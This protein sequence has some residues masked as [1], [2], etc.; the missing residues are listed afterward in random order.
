[1]KV[2]YETQPETEYALAINGALTKADLVAAIRPFRL[3]ANDGDWR[4][5]APPKP[6]R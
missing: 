6:R 5:V 2:G 3:V 1:M 4:I